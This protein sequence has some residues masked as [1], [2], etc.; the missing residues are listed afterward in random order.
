MKTHRLRH[1]RWRLIEVAAV[2]YH[3]IP[4]EHCVCVWDRTAGHKQFAR[5]GDQPVPLS[6]V[7]GFI[8]QVFLQEPPPAERQITLLG[9][10]RYGFFRG[11]MYRNQT[12]ILGSFT[13]Q[14]E[15][16]LAADQ[17]NP[18][19][20]NALK[21]MIEDP[22]FALPTDEPLPPDPEEWREALQRRGWFVYQALTVDLFEL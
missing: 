15:A 2:T 20:V 12:A 14:A 7:A 18:P 19:Y 22:D 10:N 16:R 1:Q 6:R 17:R 11:K 13:D 21:K 5:H 3:W 4:F 8:R 9:R